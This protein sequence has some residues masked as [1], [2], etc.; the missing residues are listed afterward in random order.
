MW[1]DNVQLCAQWAGMNKNVS[2]IRPQ[3]NCW[4]SIPS[5]W[6]FVHYALTISHSRGA[7]STAPV[8]IF[9]VGASLASQWMNTKCFLLFFKHN[10]DAIWILCACFVGTYW[11]VLYSAAVVWGSTLDFEYS[12]NINTRYIMTL[13]CTKHRPYDLVFTEIFTLG[14][15]CRLWHTVTQRSLSS[16]E[17]HWP[18]SLWLCVVECRRSKSRQS[19]VFDV[20]TPRSLRRRRLGRIHGSPVWES[21]RP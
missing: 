5:L 21:T 16:R 6:H 4:Y 10:R 3:G 17:K 20:E 12:H 19:F 7:C 18:V 2:K 15:W 11:H 13:P 8:N 9:P 1:C 14:D